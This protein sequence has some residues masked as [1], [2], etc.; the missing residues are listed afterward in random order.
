VNWES[1]DI[2][3]A[4]GEPAAA[5]PLPPDHGMFTPEV[6][7]PYTVY[8]RVW[9][10]GRAPILGV[11]VEF[12]WFGPHLRV[13]DQHLIGMTRVDLGPR[14]S[15]GCNKLVK[16]PVAW[17]PQSVGSISP[18]ARFSHECLLVRA[19]AIGDGVA[20]DSWDPATDRHVAVRNLN[21]VSAGWDVG[22][23]V[24]SLQANLYASG[25]TRV[26]LLQVGAEAGLSLRIAGGSMQIDPAV[27]THVLAELRADGS[28]HLPPTVASPAGGGAPFA[29][30]ALTRSPHAVPPFAPA[31]M[32]PGALLR[33]PPDGRGGK[34]TA[35]GSPTEL[36]AGGGTVRDL[37]GYHDLLSH[38]ARTQLKELRAPTGNQ[39]QVLRF[40]EFRGDQVLGGYTLIIRGA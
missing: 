21:V 38:E 39:A 32:I 35:T 12:H 25:G 22:G 34:R 6:G 4:P 11:K 28:V 10:L 23:L 20:P 16:C 5:P 31:R 18:G 17:R 26:Q 36:L 30:S 9:N 40:V 8:A 7:K 3:L 15:L 19:S 37:F 33:I 27:Q 1:P 24:Q 2:W 29:A 14:S 13:S